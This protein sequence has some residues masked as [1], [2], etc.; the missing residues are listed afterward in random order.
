MLTTT[1]TRLGPFRASWGMF[2][3]EHCCIQLGIITTLT[4]L[5]LLLLKMGI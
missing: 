5:L 3:R 4:T 2:L 1:S